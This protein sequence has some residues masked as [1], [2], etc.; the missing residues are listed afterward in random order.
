MTNE[1]KI[2]VLEAAEERGWNLV[3]YANPATE[4]YGRLLSNLSQTRLYIECLSD[5]EAF[6]PA[7]HWQAT[8]QPSTTPEQ[9]EPVPEATEGE[10][11]EDSPVEQVTPLVTTDDPKPAPAY[12]KKQ[13]VE[14]M[15]T[16][17]R[18]GINVS[19]IIRAFGVDNLG[20][21][22]EDQYPAVVEQLKKE[23]AI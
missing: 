2:A 9:A 13:L 22:P 16:A 20:D 15:K 14:M 18:N 23:G 5:P 1:E 10:P 21:I 8:E 19:Q 17:R 6:K 12:D 7:D 11:V 4:E 3:P